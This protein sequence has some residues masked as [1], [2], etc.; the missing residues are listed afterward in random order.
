MGKQRMPY[1]DIQ[2]FLL[3]LCADSPIIS[4]RLANKMIFLV[5][6]VLSDQ[7]PNSGPARRPLRL[8]ADRDRPRK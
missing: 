8:N 7:W 3:K 4:K 5:V 6:L 2:L 1:V